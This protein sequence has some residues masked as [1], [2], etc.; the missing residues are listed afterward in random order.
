MA[1]ESEAASLILNVDATSADVAKG[2]LASLTAEGKVA[3]AQVD[4]LTRASKAR[5]TA[6]LEWSAATSKVTSALATQTTQAN[7]AAKATDMLA[8]A[9]RGAAGA[10]VNLT[11]SEAALAAQTQ[12]LADSV[13]RLAGA[14]GSQHAA[15]NS[16]AAS[17]PRMAA[18]MGGLAG[19]IGA[20]G[21]AAKN[22]NYLVTNLG[23]QLND[24]ATGLAMGQ[25]PFR[26]LAQQGGQFVQIMQQAG[27]G[28][29]GLIKMMG[30]ALGPVGLIAAGVTATI[31][32]GF[33]IA[34]QQ[35]NKT[36]GDLTS[37]LGL[38]SEQLDRVSSRYVGFGDTIKATFQVAWER[39]KVGFGGVLS[40]IATGYQFMVDK[41]VWAIEKTIGVFVGGFQ[42]IKEAY[43]S[44]PTWLGGEGKSF[45]LSALGKAFSAGMKD[46]TVAVDRF[47]SDVAN[48]ARQN[49]IAE[50]IKE[51]GKAKK[52]SS[53]TDG[54]KRLESFQ[55]QTI[56]TENLAA[57]TKKLNAE[58]QAGT[59]TIGEANEQLKLEGQLKSITAEIENT[60][61]LPLK[62]KL[63]AELVKMTAAFKD[64]NKAQYEFNLLQALNAQDN[65]LEFLK[66]EGELI[67]AS[68]VERATM[69]AQ[70]KMEQEIKSG[71]YGNVSPENK[72]KLIGGATSIAEKTEQNKAELDAYNASLTETS[73]L[74]EELANNGAVAA[75]G[76]ADAFGSVGAAIG[77]MSSALM[78]HTVAQSR[79]AEEQK[80]I[81]KAR[82]AAGDNEKINAKID[83]DQVILN[84]K[85]SSSEKEYYATAL[86]SV[87][88]LFNE[89]SVMYKALNAAEG[90][91][92]AYELAMSIQAMF[93]KTAEA[94]A[95]VAAEA[96]V[97]SATLPLVAT[98]T[99]AKTAEGAASMFAW[100]GPWGFA[101]VAAMMA[102]MASLGAGGGGGG[103]APVDVAKDRQ[104]AQGAGSVLGDATAK[105]D[106]IAK[107]LEELSNNTNRDLEYSNQMVTSLRAIEDSIGGLTSLL[108]RELNVGG[109]FD[110][111]SL[112][113]GTSGGGGGGLLGGLISGLFGSSKTTTELLDQ[114]INVAAASVGDAIAGAIQANSYQTIK[115]TTEKTGA[116]F[117]LFGGGTS[118][119][120]KTNSS[121]LNSNFTSEISDIVGG[122]RATVLDAATKL[123]VEGAGAVI[124]SLSVNVGNISF[125]DMTGSEIQDALT[126][127]FSKL[128]DEM[129]SA[130]V[131]QVEA[132]QKVGEGA[133]QT[134]ARLTQEYTA[135]DNAMKLMGKSFGAVGIGSLEARDRLVQLSGGLDE[136]TSQ[137][138]FF[139]D[140]FITSAAALKPVALAVETELTRLGAASV[141]NKEQ[142]ASLVQGI[143]VSSDAG[144]KLYTQLMA[145][146]PAFAKVADAAKDLADQRGDMEIQLLEL[147]GNKLE[148]VNRA[149]AREIEALDETLR[150]LQ[151]LI[152][153]TQDLNAANEEVLEAQKELAALMPKEKTAVE[154]LTAA[155]ANLQAAYNAETAALKNLVSYAHK[156]LVDIYNEESNALQKL[157][158]KF[159]NFSASLKSYSESL[160]ASND[161]GPS[162]GRAYS[163]ARNNF[164][165]VAAAA[166]AGDETAIQN[167]Q[168][169][170]ESF[171]SASKDNSKTFVEHAMNIA[172]VKNAVDKT[173][174]AADKT[175]SVAEQQLE[176]MNKAVEGLGVVNSSILGVKSG[177]LTVNGAVDRS[178]DGLLSIN[179]SLAMSN[180]QLVSVN[181]GI[182][183]VGGQIVPLT[184]GVLSVGGN[185]LSVNGAVLSLKDGIFSVGGKVDGVGTSVSGAVGG[186][187]GSINNVVGGVA[188]VSGSVLSVKSA[189]DTLNVATA[190]QTQGQA[191]LD[192]SV[193]GSGIVLSGAVVDLAGS[194][195]AGLQGVM[196]GTLTIGDVISN[197]VAG[198]AIALNNVVFSVADAING[199]ASA[200]EASA[201]AQSSA[202]AQAQ[203]NLAAA[204]AKR[205]AA[206]IEVSNYTVNL[207]SY[208]TAAATAAAEQTA[209]IIAS[210][211]AAV[212]SA[213]T[214][215]NN[216]PVAAAPA[217]QQDQIDRAWSNGFGDSDPA[218]MEQNSNYQYLAALGFPQ[219]SW[220]LPGHAGGLSRVPY[221]NY[222]FR[223]HEGEAVLTANEASEWRGRGG[224]GDIKA[225]V[226]E[227]LNEFRKQTGLQYKTEQNTRKTSDILTNITPNGNTLQTEEYVP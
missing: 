155:R 32:T 120:T 36:S 187:N 162:D 227:L 102:V 223:A 175:V 12:R 194:L 27:G 143:D 221:D 94:G 9:E 124:D 135:V 193:Q 139:V 42:L 128:G 7:S 160:S 189:V 6:D 74:L 85:K 198:S 147:Q 190:I 186:L 164:N 79:F 14:L 86:H 195:Q 122:L 25:N 226:R 64:L 81:N 218:M 149:R 202:L 87:K 35:I 148:A 114:G 78:D 31:A 112:G 71:K 166:Q 117:G 150:P 44:M 212:V 97:T 119:S 38:T 222:L 49:K 55:K 207:S 169:A 126:S 203:S 70:L 91:Y 104:A 105:S 61:S 75:N 210:S 174:V 204:L 180:G 171:L 138:S 1:G 41:A 39:I 45:D 96:T 53:L 129:V 153:A 177:V 11:A 158:N 48:K 157:A 191:L 161:T 145:V 224:D 133:L 200:M 111:S 106:S 214:Q 199:V 116:L 99:A 196:N 121:A 62:A 57:A 30:A 90:A 172:M 115:S 26:I 33:A 108:A 134:L 16:M 43:K 176:A 54:E 50:I 165:S 10:T 197:A 132:L 8:A 29:I 220:F 98:R 219:P 127:V 65:Q 21:G 113:L 4:K 69:L 144:A 146:A 28:P 100:L 215:T 93:Q 109:L 3:E 23:F 167:L 5:A 183:S 216:T 68:N 140:N 208:N 76:L 60:K 163:I 82:K 72:T 67:G 170:G 179:G 83:A 136:F 151:A 59:K 142:F 84:L 73:R 46:G 225:E 192:K 22:S 34:S 101:A 159:T 20:V 103:A 206:Q 209:A 24:V 40:A 56:E 184:N 95:A 66:R 182:L 131:P 178:N 168:Q 18:Q 15:M 156:N 107:S 185:V 123:G 89:K 125:K 92:R 173:T 152:N 37:G 58:I 141:K 118:T 19:G 188:V 181:N 17:I 110:T 154:N 137:A 51:A 88:G 80:E 2:K 205:D 201:I 130:A 77:N 63:N 13:P 211:I 52:D 217:S 47:F 213:V